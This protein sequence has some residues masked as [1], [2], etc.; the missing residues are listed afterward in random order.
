MRHQRTASAAFDGY[1]VAILVRFAEVQLGRWIALIG[2]SPIPGDRGGSVSRN[3]NAGLIRRGQVEF[4]Q[5][6]TLF[7]RAPP[8]FDR[9]RHVLRDTVAGGVLPTES[10]LGRRIALLRRLTLRR[11]HRI[12]RSEGCS[13]G[14]PSGG[15]L[16]SSN[17]AAAG[18]LAASPPAITI[19]KTIDVRVSPIAI[20]SAEYFSRS[21]QS[22]GDTLRDTITHWPLRRATSSTLRPTP[23]TRSGTAAPPA[24]IAVM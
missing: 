21:A 24:A 12:E 11:R 14:G 6:V 13:V 17:A 7:G 20:S 18:R 15:R 8:P 5:H 2:G 1:A 9:L 22:C 10:E 23:T 19:A 3:T 4:R 16:T